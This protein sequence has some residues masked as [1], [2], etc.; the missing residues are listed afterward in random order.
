MSVILYTIDKPFSNTT[1][2]SS[3]PQSENI[4]SDWIPPVNTDMINK[5]SIATTKFK[6]VSQLPQ[7]AKNSFSW[8]NNND[9]TKYNKDVPLNFISNIC[10]S[11]LF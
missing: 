11:M 5:S 4:G 7:D 1:F 3:F 2:M 8:S 9:I 6:G 10:S